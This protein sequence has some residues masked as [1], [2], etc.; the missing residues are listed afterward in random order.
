M[1]GMRGTFSPESCASFLLCDAQHDCKHISEKGRHYEKED[2]RK[3]REG[4]VAGFAAS[5]WIPSTMAASNRI[6]ATPLLSE[7]RDLV[8]V[9]ELQ[10]L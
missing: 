9:V 10:W 8:K 3:K 6:L 4:P 5:S 2:T 1:D 7:I